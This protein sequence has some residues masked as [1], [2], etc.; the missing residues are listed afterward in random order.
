VGV[1]DADKALADKVLAEL[2]KED[3]LAADLPR[4]LH[5]LMAKHEMAREPI[6]L[7]ALTAD[8]LR[9]LEPAARRR[10]IDLASDPDASIPRVLVDCLHVQLALLNLVINAMDAMADTPAD[11][12][13]VI[14]R[15]A[16][17]A[18]GVEVSVTD[19]GHGIAPAALPRLFDS[20]FTTKENAAGL[21]LS[22]AKSIVETHGGRIWAESGEGGAT[23]RFTLPAEKAE[24]A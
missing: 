9:F 4:R 24:A 18:Q 16:R 13:R 14:V 2:R 15:T 6:D 7:N 21:G 8:L 22:I 17:T 11:L 19:R 23:F 1:N 20:F 12:R 3:L 10:N 5:A